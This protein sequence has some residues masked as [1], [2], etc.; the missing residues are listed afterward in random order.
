MCLSLL[1]AAGDKKSAFEYYTVAKQFDEAIKAV[2][3]GQVT[4]CEE[5]ELPPPAVP[6]K[7]ITVALCLS[8]AAFLFKSGKASAYD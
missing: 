7:P 1:F 4:E 8:K 5:S 6:Y 2:N 3:D